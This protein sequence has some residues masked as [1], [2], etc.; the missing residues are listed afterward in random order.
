MHFS[1]MHSSARLA[2]LVESLAAH[3]KADVSEEQT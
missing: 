1:E 2:H 3:F